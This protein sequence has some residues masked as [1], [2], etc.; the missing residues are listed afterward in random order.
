[1]DP[2][3]DDVV[4]IP[5][6]DLPQLRKDVNAVD[7]AIGPEIEENDLA[8]QILD[9]QLLTTRVNPVEARREVRGSDARKFGYRL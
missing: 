6:L 1:M 4:R 8:T 2:D 9:A 3:D 5:L 7:S